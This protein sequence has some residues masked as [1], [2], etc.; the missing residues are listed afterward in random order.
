MKE[1]GGCRSK[2]HL[3]RVEVLRQVL[4]EEEDAA[5]AFD[6]EPSEAVAEEEGHPETNGADGIPETSGRSGGERVGKKSKKAKKKAARAR[7]GGL[8]AWADEAAGNESAAEESAAALVNDSDAEEPRASLSAEDEAAS[9]CSADED[10]TLDAMLHM[11]TARMQQLDASEASQSD[12]ESAGEA[13]DP[14]EK[15]SVNAREDPLVADIADILAEA[16]LASNG[17]L[18]GML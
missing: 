11:Q 18:L 15:L 3:E 4:E 10:S 9:A 12:A 5:A 7:A 8:G 14:P 2:K 6:Y 17:T 1:W 16:D 13:T